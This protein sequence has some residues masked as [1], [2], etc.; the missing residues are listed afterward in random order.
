[1]EDK[2]RERDYQDD[3]LDYYDEVQAD[4]KA[5]YIKMA[6]LTYDIQTQLILVRKVEA[7]QRLIQKQKAIADQL[8]AIYTE[9]EDRSNRKRGIVVPSVFE[10]VD[11]GR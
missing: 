4:A 2:P 10:A 7:W 8:A 5:L 11:D 9:I 3:R 1:M 6:T